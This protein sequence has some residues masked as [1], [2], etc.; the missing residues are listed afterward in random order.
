MNTPQTITETLHTPVKERVDVLVCGG[1][2]AGCGAALAAARLNARVRLV[3]SY[4]FLGGVC[5]AG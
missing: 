1:G 2:P 5:S 4:G 3:E